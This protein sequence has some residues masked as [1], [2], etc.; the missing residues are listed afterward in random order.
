MFQKTK[1]EEEWCVW[2]GK[3][4]GERKSGVILGGYLAERKGDGE[5]EKEG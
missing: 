3:G 4:G 2:E 5:R 1:A